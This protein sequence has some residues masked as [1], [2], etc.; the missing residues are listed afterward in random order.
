MYIDYVIHV[1]IEVVGLSMMGLR[2][3]KKVVT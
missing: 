3:T 2:T 1:S